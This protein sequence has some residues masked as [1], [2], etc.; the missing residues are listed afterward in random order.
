MSGP[1]GLVAVP[2]VVGGV[3]AALLLSALAGAGQPADS[4]PQAP[5]RAVLAAEAPAHPAPEP[6][7]GTVVG[8]QV[9][10]GSP[11]PTVPPPTGTP[12]G[13][14]TSPQPKPSPSRT[15]PA[16]SGQPAPSGSGGLPTTGGA[17]G[18]AWPLAVG[19]ASV[20]LGLALTLAR[21]RRHREA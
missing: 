15:G 7:D 18:P 8:F 1:I 9:L 12:T 20:L 14:P 17:W 13:G 5:P 11:Q 19:T 16:P 2:R 21:R 4:A 10:P 3:L 6:S